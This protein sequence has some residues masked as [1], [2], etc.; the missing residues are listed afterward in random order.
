MITKTL[1]AI[2]FIFTVASFSLVGAQET[3][4]V[5]EDK[6]KKM[7]NHLDMNADDTITLEE[8]K[9]MRVKDPSKADQ[10]EKRFTSM[11]TDKNGTVDRVEFKAFMERPREAKQKKVKPTKG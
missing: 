11:D 2:I 1:K 3:V 9:K 4:D 5:T 6:S 10:V 7:F 8:F